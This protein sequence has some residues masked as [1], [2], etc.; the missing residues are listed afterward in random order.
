[1]VVDE[2]VEMDIGCVWH[3]TLVLDPGLVW[4]LT[5]VVAVI[6]MSVWV[7]A[8]LALI[9]GACLA[10]TTFIMLSNA[11]FATVYPSSQPKSIPLSTPSSNLLSIFFADPSILLFSPFRSLLHV[12]VSISSRGF[13][14][15]A[16]C[17]R[18]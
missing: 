17:L 7:L 3:E 14:P 6:S 15:L 11:S 4:V 1:M 16:L 2:G 12:P 13:C 5:D 18:A 9:S 10:F 8:S